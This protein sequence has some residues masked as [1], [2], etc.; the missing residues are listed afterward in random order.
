ML[1][2]LLLL[3]VKSRACRYDIKLAAALYTIVDGDMSWADVILVALL[4]L[5]VN[6]SLTISLLVS[7]MILREVQRM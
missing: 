7:L 1:L 4:F 5:A 3:L 6:E 2:L